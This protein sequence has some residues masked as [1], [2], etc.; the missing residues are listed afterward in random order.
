MAETGLRW[1]RL[2]FEM[3]GREAAVPRPRFHRF[4]MIDMGSPCVSKMGLF[5]MGNPEWGRRNY[6]KIYGPQEES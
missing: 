5:S 4:S 2:A 1:P 6:G 3:G